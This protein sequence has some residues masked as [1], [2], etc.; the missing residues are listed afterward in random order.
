MRVRAHISML[1]AACLLAA[2]LLFYS[3][4][5]VKDKPA[6][7]AATS[8]DNAE[9]LS[10]VDPCSETHAFGD[11]RPP[12]SGGELVLVTGGAGFIGSNLV[13]RLLSLG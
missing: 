12:K 1:L 9:Y 8:A 2:C 6:F 4:S 11:V 13:D 10:A 7:E 3:V 5:A